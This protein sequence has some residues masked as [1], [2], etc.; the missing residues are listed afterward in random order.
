M[1]QRDTHD[2]DCIV[3]TDKAPIPHCAHAQAVADVD[4]LRELVRD[5]HI[6]LRGFRS[7]AINGSPIQAQIDAVLERYKRW[8]P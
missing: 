3:R 4:E 8:L 6:W 2:R 7:L 5:S 1:C